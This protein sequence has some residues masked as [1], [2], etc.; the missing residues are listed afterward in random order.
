MQ[1]VVR[2]VAPQDRAGWNLLYAAY[3]RFYETEQ[4]PDMR[5][6]VWGWLM[7]PAHAVCGQVAETPAGLI[8]LTHYRPF[9]RPL[10]ASTGIYLDDLFVDPAARGSGAADLLIEAVRVVAGAQGC[11][12]VRWITAADNVR[13]QKVYDRMASRTAWVTYDLGV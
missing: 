2:P 5:D 11:G 3:A 10:A 9:A 8:G 12:V 4:T 7:D 6:R 13:A 1:I